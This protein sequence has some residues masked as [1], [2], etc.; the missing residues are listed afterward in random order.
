MNSSWKVL[1]SKMYVSLNYVDVN[2]FV[3]V[4]QT[5]WIPVETTPTKKTP[6]V[7]RE[8]GKHEARFEQF[9]GRYDPGQ[10]L[11]AERERITGTKDPPEWSYLHRTVAQ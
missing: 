9:G 2:L 10:Q 7:F 6:T 3:L 1:A 4:R 11:A 8:S 5:K